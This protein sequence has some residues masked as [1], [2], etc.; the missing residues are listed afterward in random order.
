MTEYQEQQ[1]ASAAGNPIQVGPG[2]EGGDVAAGPGT[3]GWLEAGPVCGRGQPG[4][5]EEQWNEKEVKGMSLS[6]SSLLHALQVTSLI[7]TQQTCLGKRVTTSCHGQ[8][9]SLMVAWAS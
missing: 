2:G 1:S 9:S 3:L 4:R 7:L 6:Q 5:S 8:A